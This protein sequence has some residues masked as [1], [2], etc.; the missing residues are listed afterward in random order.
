MVSGER[1][2][3]GRGVVSASLGGYKTP[4]PVL[5]CW[6]ESELGREEEAVSAAGVS[7]PEIQFRQ[8]SVFFRVL[9]PPI[10]P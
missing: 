6:I 10:S 8:S 4:T 3:R 2:V 9:L 5:H 1:C 7:A